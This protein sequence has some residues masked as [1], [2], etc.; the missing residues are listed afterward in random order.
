[1]GADTPQEKKLPTRQRKS[2]RKSRQGCG[3]CKL[4]SIKVCFCPPITPVF[5]CI[6][7]TRLSSYAHSP[8]GLATSRSHLQCDETKPTCKRCAAS[9]FSCNYSRAAPA[10]QLAHVG[11]F[12]L[13]LSPGLPAPNPHVSIPVM[14]PVP[15][16]IGDY[17]MK[18]ED[19]ATL[20][21]FHK[22][23]VLHMGTPGTRKLFSH[24]AFGLGAS[25]SLL[26]PLVP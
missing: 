3:N 14:L 8:P 6:P 11:A 2:H 19:F 13:D 9:G 16:R 12:K 5:F 17:R 18:A 22:R 20:D 26:Q 23:T 21:R 7:R 24:E 10:L 4:R 25:V 15:G 1:M